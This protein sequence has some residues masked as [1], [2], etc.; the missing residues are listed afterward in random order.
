[1]EMF[2]READLA[3]KKRGSSPGRGGKAGQA[4]FIKKKT[5]TKKMFE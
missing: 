3:K 4:N 1:M 5:Y 2:M